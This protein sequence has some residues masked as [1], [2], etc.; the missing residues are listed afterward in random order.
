MRFVGIDV[1]SETH[2]VAVLD[3]ASQVLVRPTAFTEDAGGYQEL[4]GLLAQP[5]DFAGMNKAYAAV[6]AK[7]PPARAVARLGPELPGIR[8]SIM[9]TAHIPD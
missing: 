6:F 9:V 3:E 8:V 2:V 4:R 7:D 1:G 5:D